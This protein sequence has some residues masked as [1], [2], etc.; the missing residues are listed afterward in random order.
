VQVRR[1]AAA[2]IFAWAASC[3]AASVDPC[4]AN[5]LSSPVALACV[6]GSAPTMS[7]RAES[8]ET[9]EEIVAATRSV[10]LKVRRSRIGYSSLIEPPAEAIGVIRFEGSVEREG[11]TRAYSRKRFHLR[12]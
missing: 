2:V 11:L 8:R 12:P 1:C 9:I 5:V 3:V 4:G 6:E 10:D 7:L